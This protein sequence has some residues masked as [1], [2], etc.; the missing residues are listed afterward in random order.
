MFSRYV[1]LGDSFTEGV[2]DPYPT[3]PNG[4]RG[5]A[6]HVAVALAQTNPE[7]RY[8]N[9]A[10]R[11]G[12]M[13]EILNEQV[14]TAVMLEPDLVTI[15]AGMNNLLLVRNDVDAMMAR[16]ADGLKTLQQTGAVVLAFTAADLGTVPLFRRLR[17]GRRCTTNCCAT[18][19]TTSVC[20]SSTSGG[21]PSFAMHAC[22][23][24]IASISRRSVI[25]RF[26]AKVLDTL[27]VSHELT[28]RS[29]ALLRRRRRCATSV[30]TFDG[31]RR[32][33][34]RGSPNGC[35]ARQP[36]AGIEPKSTTLTKVL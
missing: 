6:D 20:N 14:Q 30:R 25:E 23:T 32:S 10:V 19:P 29:A 31:P 28:T 15:Y 5:W 34:R 2:G 22:G 33:P 3:S 8:A 24:A 16:Y 13:D 18:S 26:A 1:A 27:A 11:G 17:G 35:G 9:L 4:L 12:R 7:L 21:S 36:G